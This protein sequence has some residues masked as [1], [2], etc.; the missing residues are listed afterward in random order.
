MRVSEQAKRKR[1]KAKAE[2][3]PA[4]VSQPEPE[5]GGSLSA[6]KLPLC[7][8]VCGSPVRSRYHRRIMFGLD[9]V[10]D[11]ECPDCGLHLYIRRRSPAEALLLAALKES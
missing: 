4:A 10:C 7:C 11:S 8:P 2:A 6:P 1:R 5:A 9:V 3:G